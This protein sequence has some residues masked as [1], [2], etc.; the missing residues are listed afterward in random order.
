[1]RPIKFELNISNVQKY[2]LWF[3]VFF[4]LNYLG[5]GMPPIAGLSFH[6]LWKL[7]VL[8]YLLMLF[9]NSKRKKE[10]FEIVTL[11]L[12]FEYFLNREMVVNPLGCIIRISKQQLPFVLLFSYW[13]TY[14]DQKGDTLQKIMISMAQFVALSTIPFFLGVLEPLKKQMSLDIFGLE[15]GSYFMG[16]FGAPHAASSIFC[17]AIFILIDGFQKGKFTNIKEKVINIVF[18]LLLFVGVFKAFVRTGWLMLIVGFIFYFDWKQL[19][20]KHLQKGLL[21]ATFAVIGVLYLFNN[22]EAFHA[23]ITGRNI[24]TGRGDDEIETDGSGRM[25]FWK[26]AVDGL[27][28]ADNPFYTLLGRGETLVKEENLRNTGMRV[29]SHNQF[30]DALAQNGIIGLSLLLC[31]YALLYKYIIRRKSQYKRLCIALF[32]SSVIFAFFQSEVYFFYAFM[33]SIAVALHG[34]ESKKLEKSVRTNIIIN[35][36]KNIQ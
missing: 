17:C 6:Q 2:I 7:P 19:N 26:N 34:I 9:A 29:F 5:D 10:P 4:L 3:L 8:A 24:Y 18:I 31:Y 27:W 15:N 16:I 12:I 28:N 22:N 20:V 33:F 35:T 1:M 25:E 23:R 30:M 32:M 14:Y 13:Y 11:I 36:G 21:F